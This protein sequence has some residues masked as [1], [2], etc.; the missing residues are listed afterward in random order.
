MK[1]TLL[2]LFYLP[3]IGFGQFTDSFSDGEFTNN[4]NWLGSVG[5][6][7]VDTNL[8]LHL[9]DSIANSSSLI[10]QSQSII[11]GEWI[12][13]VK[14][15]FAPSTNNYARVYLISDEQDLTG[16][17]HGYFVKIGGQTGTVDEISL[18]SQNGTN[19]TKIIDGI[20]SLASN[21]PDI[22]VKVTRDILGNWEL[23]LDTNGVFFT[24][25]IVFDNS[26]TSSDYFGI[27][28][29]Y[30]ITRSDKFW[31][32]DFNISGS[33]AIYGCTDST[34]C[35]YD[36]TA[37]CDDG[38][39]ILPDGCSDPSACNYDA[40]AICDDGLCDLP[41]GCGDPLYAEYNSLVTCSDSLDCITFISTG[42]LN[43]NHVEKFLFK[44]TDMLGQET[45]YRKNTPL[46][47]LYDDGTIEKRIVIE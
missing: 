24:Q 27:F 30:T 26:V 39:C 32:D 12:F 10:T 37:T 28:C 14:L 22:K 46:F 2:I 4:P 23:F 5:V 18:Y 16:N 25:G 33:S 31:F 1:K 11:N 19:H 3:M 34:A 35:N 43:I 13:S 6:F 36:L 29:K 40:T 7:E 47:Y 42:R 38:L 17:L 41:N 15:D 44:I 21:N 8:R 20:D 9:N 45:P